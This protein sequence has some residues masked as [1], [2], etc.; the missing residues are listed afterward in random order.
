[1]VFGLTEHGATLPEREPRWQRAIFAYL[2]GRSRA[3]D[4]RK[5][6]SVVENQVL[7]LASAKLLFSC[8]DLDGDALVIASAGP[9]STNGSSAVLTGTS[10]AYQPTVNFVGADRFSYTIS[11]GRGGTATAFPDTATPLNILPMPMVPGQP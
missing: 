9:A 6:A 4:W 8:T 3:Q 1:L 10:I 11:D 7:N 2:A 5:A